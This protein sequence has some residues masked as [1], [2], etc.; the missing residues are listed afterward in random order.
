M[1]DAILDTIG[2]GLGLALVFYP[3]TWL[4]MRK[5][6]ELRRFSDSKWGFL[7]AVVLLPPLE[8]IGLVGGAKSNPGLVA[9]LLMPIGVCALLVYISRPKRDTQEPMK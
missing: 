3:L 6:F 8:A 9:G 2:Q 5:R 1:Y 4:A 7:G